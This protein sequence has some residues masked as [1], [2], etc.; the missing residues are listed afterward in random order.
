MS[1]R[2]VNIKSR[3]WEETP[4]DERV[5]IGHPSF[6]VNPYRMLYPR[7]KAVQM[8]EKY[9][10]QNDALKARIHELKDK[11]LGCPG[12]CKPLACHGDVLARKADE[13]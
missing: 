7:D 5:M 13:A 6:W 10:E 1:T 4:E 3:E 11:V 12:N 9:Y 8:F 2:V